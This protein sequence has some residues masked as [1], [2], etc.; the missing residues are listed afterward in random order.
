MWHHY[1]AEQDAHG[2][3]LDKWLSAQSQLSRT[4]IQ[5]LI[6]N[7]H[8]QAGGDLV[9]DPASKICAGTLYSVTA[10]PPTPVTPYA[11]P[12]PLDIVYEDAALLVINKSAGM[13]VHP[14]TSSQTGT[15]VH[16][17]LHHCQDTLSSIGGILRPGI[18]HRIDKNTSGLM[19]VAKNNP[20]HQHLAQQ[21]ARHSLTR[22]YL[23]FTRQSPPESQGRIESRL[24]RAPQDRTKQ[25]V[26][27]GTFGNINAH[28]QGRHAITYYQRTHTYGQRP[29]MAIGTPIASRT[30]CRLETGRTHQIR[31]HMAHLGCP[32]FG[33]PLYGRHTKVP[34]P[35]HTPETARS[36]IHAFDRQALHAARLGFTHPQTRQTLC[37]EATLP[38]DMQAL[39]TALEQLD[40]I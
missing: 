5:A 1:K 13:T 34:L 2:Q 31:V 32:L 30:E 21:F 29:G 33:D 3:R 17:L 12:I 6:R 23:C 35:R 24:T 20:V 18:V 26:V 39:Q 38:P 9:T 4:R 28:T 25:A 8:V 11:Q 37:F 10:L 40:H 27:K 7:A 16:A 36:I 15:L 14:A 19:V 22:S